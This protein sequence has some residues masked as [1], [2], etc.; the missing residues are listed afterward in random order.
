MMSLPQSPLRLQRLSRLEPVPSCQRTLSHILIHSTRFLSVFP[1]NRVQ[2]SSPPRPTALPLNI[3][4][5]TS[6]EPSR[7]VTSN[8]MNYFDHRLSREPRILLLAA[9]TN[10]RKAERHQTPTSGKYD[11]LAMGQRRNRHVEC[12][13][14]VYGILP[15]G[16]LLHLQVFRLTWLS[17]ITDDMMYNLGRRPRA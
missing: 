9:F 14:D 3:V 16:E 12:T 10:P 6:S 13:E 5:T 1:T 2:D 7:P 15:P 11:A 8:A 17:H 4:L